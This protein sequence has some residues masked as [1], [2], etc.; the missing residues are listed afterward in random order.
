ML[1]PDPDWVRH[2]P[3]AKLPDRRDFVHYARD[4]PGRIKAWSGAVA[5]SRQLAEEF[6][7]WL[8]RPDVARIDPL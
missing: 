1:A 7:Q 3:N 2:L 5:A 8:D 4:L 6:A